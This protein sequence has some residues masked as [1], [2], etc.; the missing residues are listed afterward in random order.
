[1]IRIFLLFLISFLI[2]ITIVYLIN[3]IFDKRYMCWIFKPIGGCSL[4]DWI[5]KKDNKSC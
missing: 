5:N 3:I 1:M 2:F 4:L